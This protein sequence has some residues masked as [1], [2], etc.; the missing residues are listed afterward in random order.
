MFALLLVPSGWNAWTHRDMPQLG[1]LH[2]D[3][4]YVIAGRS[5]AQGLGSK[6]PSLPGEPAQT[7]YP[8]LLPA[9][10][11]LVWLAHPD[12]FTIRP[13]LTGLAWFSMPLLL[14]ALAVTTA[15]TAPPISRVR[16]L[17]WHFGQVMSSM[18]RPYSSRTGRLSSN[19][20]A[21]RPV[22][23]GILQG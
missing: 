1:K 13:A 12:P 19:A 22:C 10:V 5:I 4:L 7:K 11:S 20:D 21:G 2:D 3:S 8:P 16:M 9:L 17:P 23:R 18:V 6:I 15:T 14:A